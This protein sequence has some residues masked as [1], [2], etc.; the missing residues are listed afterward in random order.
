MNHHYRCFK[1]KK[2]SWLQETLM[3][4][5]TISNYIFLILWKIQQSESQIIIKSFN[6]MEEI[7]KK[8]SFVGN[9]K[10]LRETSYGV[11]EKFGKITK[12]KI[13]LNFGKIFFNRN[14]KEI[15]KYVYD[16]FNKDIETKWTYKYDDK[17]NVIEKNDY[18]FVQHL[19]TKSFKNKYYKGVL[20]EQEEHL[21]NHLWKKIHYKYDDKLN[22]VQQVTY[23]KYGEIIER[24]IYRYDENGNV[25]TKKWYLN[26]KLFSHKS[27]K[28]TFHK[29]F[30]KC[31]VYR[32]DK[33]RRLVGKEIFNYDENGNIIEEIE[34]HTDGK[35]RRTKLNLY[36]VN[37]NI[38]KK[39][40]Y[41][42][43]GI[44]IIK[45]N[46]QYNNNEQLTKQ[47]NYDYSIS[48]LK[49]KTTFDFG[50]ISYK[51]IIDFDLNNNELEKKSFEFELSSSK[52]YSFKYDKMGNKLERDTFDKDDVLLSRDIYKY[53]D[54][55]H[56]IE[57]YEYESD[58]KLK[59][60]ITYEFDDNGKCIELK[61][62]NSDKILT[63]THI[64]TYN[65]NGNLIKSI[66]VKSDKT[67]MKHIIKYDDKGNQIE[68]VLYNPDRN[69]RNNSFYQYK[70]DKKDNWIVKIRYDKNMNPKSITERE[71]EYY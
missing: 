6:K 12:G 14:G 42:H 68:D 22:V 66:L 40:V 38:I 45:N 31:L 37:G 8:K 47:I 23:D 34:Y 51:T 29:D 67:I 54:I 59:E 33:R 4:Y 70:F 20:V 50:C 56:L 49:R 57:G 46:F 13:I 28:Y 52:K 62:Y 39:K 25:I 26:N 64:L 16:R 21:G 17:G 2:S 43:K 7:N 3:I 19:S 55:G 11:I 5:V 24:I 36:N 63:R 30:Y 1:E 71:I 69:K 10:S 32:E 15:E 35:I 44:M 65:E 18:M 61:V 53:N 27:Y 9:V 41:N 58:G 60:K 48:L